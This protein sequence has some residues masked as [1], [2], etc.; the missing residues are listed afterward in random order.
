[1]NGYELIMKIQQ[2]MQDP[3]FANKFNQMVAELNS[4]PGLQN[5]VMKIAQISDEK[6]RKKAI[7]KLPDRSK[8]AVNEI[9]SL[10]QE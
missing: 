9:L 2:K 1:M 7:D 4:I 5:E 6:K 3:T 10:L 8:K